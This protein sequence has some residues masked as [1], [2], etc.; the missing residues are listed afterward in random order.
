MDIF[1]LSGKKI[2][3]FRDSLGWTRE[4]L[5]ELSEVPAR[6]IQDIETGKTDN[7]GINTLLPLLRAMAPHIPELSTKA[8]PR[9]DLVLWIVESLPTLDQR[10]LRG[11]RSFIEGLPVSPSASRKVGL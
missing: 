10:E 1:D 8:D 4:Y 7:P 11:V 2:R 9:P 3:E 6:T 5:S